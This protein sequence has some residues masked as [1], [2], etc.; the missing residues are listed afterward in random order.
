MAT[1]TATGAD[2]FTLSVRLGRV[3]SVSASETTTF[4]TSA[5]GRNNHI[6]ISAADV[7]SLTDDASDTGLFTYRLFAVEKLRFTERSRKGRQQAYPELAVSTVAL[8]GLGTATKQGLSAAST[9]ATFS[10]VATVIRARPSAASDTITLAGVAASNH[11]LPSVG[12][13]HLL[14]TGVAVVTVERNG[15]RSILAMSDGAQA[16]TVLPNGL[17]VPGG[18]SNA[19]LQQVIADISPWLPVSCAESADGLVLIANGIDPM[20][21]WDGVSEQ[22]WPAGLVAPDTVVWLDGSGTGL[23][24]GV[25]YAFTRWVDVD[26]NVSNLSPVSDSV[27]LGTDGLIGGVSFDSTGLV[28]VHSK[29]HGR[30]T[31]QVLTIS[32]VGG[33]PI[34]NGTWPIAVVDQDN[35]TLSGLFVTGGIYTSGGHWTFGSAQI[36]Y[37]NVPVPTN[38]RVAR[39]Q[40]LRNLEGIASVFYVDI[41]T[42]DIVSTSFS[43]SLTDEQ[44]ATA[45]SVSLAREDGTPFSQR[46]YT[47]PSHKKAVVAY[48]GRVFATADLIYST[49]NIDVALGSQVVTGIGTA[50]TS[51]MA[52]RL[53][54][55]EGGTRGQLIESVDAERQVLVLETPFSGQSS[56]IS[57]YAIRPAPVERRLVYFSEPNLPEAWPPWNAFAVPESSDEIVGMFVLRNFLYILKE[58]HLY[59]FA[60]REDP[61]RDGYVF[62]VIARGCVNNRCYAQVEARYLV[63]DEMGVYSFDG[64]TIEP[65]S[66][67]VQSLFKPDGNTAYQVDWTTDRTLWSCVQDP[68]REVV[69]WFVDFVGL[70]TLTYA[71]CYDYRRQAW[72]LEQ[73]PEAITSSWL[74]V[75]GGFRQA[76]LGT[77]A[78]RVM[79][80]SQGN[81]DMIDDEVAG[82]LR[83][84]AT[85]ADQYTLTDS[86]ATFPPNL[87]A[88]PIFIA[89]GTGAGQYA[90]ISENTATTIVVVKGWDVIPDLTSVYQIGGVQWSWKSGWRRAADDESEN[91]RDLELVF[92]PCPSAQSMHFSFY[93]DHATV[94]ANEWGYGQTSDGIAI[95][96]SVSEAVVDLTTSRGYVTQRMSAHRDPY[97]FGH[98]YLAVKLDGVQGEDAARLYHVV[99]NGFE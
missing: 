48:S 37:S 43:S 58:R 30:Q 46:F 53:L 15:G 87:A 3:W 5:K 42:A 94:P 93:F 4:S 98:R 11:F 68:A 65:V 63:L 86:L 44:L 35:F 19:G 45:Q 83:G 57:F 9:G 25:R 14:F 56:S 99:I 71:I 97:G 20:F 23:L 51:A 61:G 64:D 39:R 31:G 34:T 33:I 72:W 41:D 55:A 24:T 29:G 6:S 85:A 89:D 77:T 10:D 67:A 82:T 90:I 16:V 28:T 2:T 60:Y 13:G 84:T 21:A 36:D 73:Y 1:F 18:D 12:T 47:P 75:V 80:L 69:R 52:G 32:G 49:G 92:A 88:V 50:W 38:P 62:P 40:I 54:Y 79:T 70:P 26:G 59:K 78:R 74:A 7:L 76:V 27:D 17:T 96:A 91:P 22:A 81:L 8:A 95:T 66:A